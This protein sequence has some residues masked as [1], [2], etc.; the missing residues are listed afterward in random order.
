MLGQNCVNA[1]KP[2]GVFR[3]EPHSLFFDLRELLLDIH[4]HFLDLDELFVILHDP[5]VGLGLVREKDRLILYKRGL[6][7]DQGRKRVFQLTV[8]I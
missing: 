1:G 2:L 3:L 4:Q 6:R 5:L 7:L 8:A